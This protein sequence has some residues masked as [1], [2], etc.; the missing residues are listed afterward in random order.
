M[1]GTFA[2]VRETPAQDPA[3]RPTDLR[4][5]RQTALTRGDSPG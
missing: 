2:K 1:R 4:R 3:Y 5:S